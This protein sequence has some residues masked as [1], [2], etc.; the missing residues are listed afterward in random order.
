MKTIALNLAQSEDRQ[1]VNQPVVLTNEQQRVVDQILGQNGYQQANVV[2]QAVAGSGKSKTL[3]QIAIQAIKTNPHFKMLILVYNQKL[4][5]E[6]QAA[7]NQL[8]ARGVLPVGALIVKTYHSFI[9]LQAGIKNGLITN[10]FLEADFQSNHVNQNL[11]FYLK[12]MK[13]HNQSTRNDA[14]LWDFTISYLKA[15]EDPQFLGQWAPYFQ[16]F[17]VVAFDEAQDLKPAYWNLARIMIKIQ[18]YQSVNLKINRKSHFVIVGDAMQTIYRHEG[19]DPRYLTLLKQ[20]L[21]QLNWKQLHLS[22]SFRTTTKIAQLIQVFNPNHPFQASNQDDQCDPVVINIFDPVVINKSNQSQKASDE[23]LS[24]MFA[25]YKALKQTNGADLT[26]IKTQLQQQLKHRYDAAFTI[27]KAINDK[28]KIEHYQPNEI[29]VLSYLNVDKSKQSA[30][31]IFLDVIRQI[32]YG[33]FEILCGLESQ[34]ANQVQFETFHKAKG[35]E[36]KAVFVI[37]CSDQEVRFNESQYLINKNDLPN[38]HYVAFSRAKQFL[39][40]NVVKVVSD[41][42]QVWQAMKTNVLPPYMASHWHHLL[43]LENQNIVQINIGATWANQQHI[44]KKINPWF[45]DNCFY[46]KTGGEAINLVDPDLISAL[47][48]LAVDVETI[49][50]VAKIKAPTY[51]SGIYHQIDGN[52][53]F[54]INELLAFAMIANAQ[55]VANGCLQLASDYGSWNQVLMKLHHM[56]ASGLKNIQSNLNFKDLIDFINNENVLKQTQVLLKAVI[57]DEHLIWS[58]HWSIWNALSETNHHLKAL[59]QLNLKQNYFYITSDLLTFLKQG[60]EKSEWQIPA[61]RNDFSANQYPLWNE[62]IKIINDVDQNLKTISVDLDFKID[63]LYQNIMVVFSDFAKSTNQLLEQAIA[64]CFLM[65][66]HNELVQWIINGKGK[67]WVQKLKLPPVQPFVLP[68]V[69]KI[70]DW[71]SGTI[72]Q[73]QLDYQLVI[74]I[75]KQWLTNLIKNQ[76]MISDEQFIAINRDLKTNF[77]IKLN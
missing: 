58:A 20:T 45:N 60:W 65:M 33:Y 21:P 8:V 56:Q 73:W 57:K 68:Q 40:I 67:Q 66:L 59:K 75:G 69:L 15:L 64:T 63:Y 44:F 72:Y 54:K 71:E 4:Q 42:N 22:K 70:V 41:H 6:N 37:G 23:I 10:G 26:K 55:L 43:D 30:M 38:S 17:D 25:R 53:R 3:M 11:Q 32:L 74:A 61:D 48:A 49:T 62:I 18:N 9:N 34:S 29:V 1:Q 7:I 36:W 14:G 13:D 39:S 52:D 31:R 19:A 5:A 35:R 77:K 24:Q 46:L 27:A 47:K 12:W 2:V 50:N 28:I 51:L 76:M 16:H